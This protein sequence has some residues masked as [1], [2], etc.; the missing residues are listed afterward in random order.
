M[1]IVD[2]SFKWNWIPEKRKGTD[3]IILHH[4]AGHGTVED[5]HRI[6]Q[7]QGWPGIG[8]HFYVRRDGTVYR[9]RPEDQIGTH[10]SHYNARTIGVCFEGN[11]Q[12]ETMPEAQYNAGVAL[13]WYLLDKYGSLGIKGHRDYNQT[14]CPGQNFP[15]DEMKEDAMLT[16]KMIYDRLTEYLGTLPEPSWAQQTGEWQ[17]A[18]EEGLTDGSRPNAPCTRAETAAMILRSQK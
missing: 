7:A 18:K 15:F 12:T 16:G 8:Y 4:S 9:G 5:V 14:A 2:A 17:K 10:T 3:V 6:H 1:Q 11:F 13:L